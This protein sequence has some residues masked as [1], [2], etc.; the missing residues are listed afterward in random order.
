[1]NIFGFRPFKG[2]FNLGNSD[3]IPENQDGTLIGSIKQIK[4]ALS[5]KTDKYEGTSGGATYVTVDA[6]GYDATNKKL[7]LKV[8]GADT[9]IPFS[10]G[11]TLKIPYSVRAQHNL[12]ASYSTLTITYLD[13]S[14]AK[15]EV[16]TAYG[17]QEKYASGSWSY[18]INGLPFSIT[19]IGRDGA[20]YLTVSSTTSNNLGMTGNVGISV[21]NSSY[22]FDA[23]AKMQFS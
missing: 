12:N 10:G 5:D 19:I 1:M 6:I 23:T 4:S 2:K 8:N 22:A 9:V 14:T 20:V 7:G 17:T 13:G 21:P 3:D 18:T 16:K 11:N 15:S